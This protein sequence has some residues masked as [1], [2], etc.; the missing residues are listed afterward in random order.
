M[1]SNIEEFA[2]VGDGFTAALVGR[3]GT[4]AWL[5]LPCF[6]SAA[7]M[8]SLLGSRENGYWRIAPTA[9][10][11]SERRYRDDTLILETTF[12][13]RSGRAT[14]T[15]FM[16][17]EGR[18]SSLIRIVRGIEGRIR[19]RMEL[20]LRFDYGHRV[21]WVTREK[22]G[23]LVAIAGPDLVVLHTPVEHRGEELKTIAE[24]TVNK[25]DELPFALTY[26]ASFSETPAAPDAAKAERATGRYWHR[27]AK[28]CNY[29]GPWREAVIRSLI[30]LK[31]LI[32]RPTGGIV[33]APTA[34]I[35]ELPGGKRN[36]DYRYCW[37]RD[38]T[39]TLLAFMLAGYSAEAEA[40]RKWLIKSLAGTA[41]QLQPLY[42][43][44]GESRIAEV[45]LPWLAGFGGARPVRIGNA[46]YAQRQSDSFGEVL[47]AL[48]HARVMRLRGPEADWAFQCHLL[49]HLETVIDVP[50]HGIWETR[51][52]PRHYVH[53]K[54]MMWAAF[55]RGIRAVEQFG[56]PGSMRRWKH[57]RRK[58]H[59]EICG[60]GVDRKTGTFKRAYNDS[61]MDA[62]NLL[63]PL[64]GFLP[65][66]DPRV[67]GTIAKIESDLM[68]G[69]LVRRYD[70][71][72]VKDGFP[73]GEGAFLACSF[74]LADNMILQGR[75]EDAKALFERLLRLRNDVGLLAEEYDPGRRM[76]VGNFPQA[77]S[78]LALVGTAYN[79]LDES[80]PAHMRSGLT[81]L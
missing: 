28:R 14:V 42:T 45:E 27:W 2:I 41:A 75:I 31:A 18:S 4:V 60:R 3:D 7:C 47:D 44:R 20:V 38:S 1:I 71:Y 16:P 58:L 77:L 78:H 66:Q 11:R 46:A 50:C 80:G 68:R 8:A 64:V 62:A 13:T 35:P 17:T 56:L 79:L 40:W 34:S 9:A 29:Q 25:G 59:A 36:W 53:T 72:H 37:L 55:D 19:F 73:P 63:I 30:T 23:G 57:L 32:Y 6:D 33:A 26:G 12:T 48:H 74:W 81:R 15:D 61:R 39:F 51:D 70:T 69:G 54:V 76:Q 10:H 43:V 5:C 22:G 65:P 52:R 67:A 21:P 24:F 49:K